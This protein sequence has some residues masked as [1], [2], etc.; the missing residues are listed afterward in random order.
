MELLAKLFE[1][2]KSPFL[3]TLIFLISGSISSSNNASTDYYKKF[4][5]SSNNFK[6]IL[7]Y[8][9][10]PS[11]QYRL[12]LTVI[13][14]SY[15]IR[16]RPVLDDGFP[17]LERFTATSEV[18]INV[19]SITNESSNLIV[20]HQRNLTIYQDR[21][22][23]TNLET[24]QNIRIASQSFQTDKDFYIIELEESFQLGDR[25]QIFIP[26]LVSMSQTEN[27]GIYVGH[28]IDPSTN[29]TRYL[30]TTKLEP[31]HARKVFPLFNE[32]S[33]KATFNITIGRL[34][35]K[36]H[37]LSNMEITHIEPDQEHT[38]WVW[39]HYEETVLMSP[40]LV[41][42]IVS[43]FGNQ[44]VQIDNGNRTVSTWALRHDIEQN[45][46]LFGAETGARILKYFENKFKM[47]YA[48][49]KLDAVGLP[50]FASGAMENFGLVTYRYAY[51][52]WIPGENT[53]AERRKIAQVLAHEIAHQWYG[54]IVTCAWWSEIWLNEGFARYLQFWGMKE[55]IPEFATDEAIVNDVTQLAMVFDQGPLTHPVK[56][57]A[58]SPEE[59][60][61]VFDRVSYEKAAS[62]LK[63]MEGFL[64][65]PI[66]EAGF[67]DVYLQ[68][69]KWKSAYQDD[70]FE[71]VQDAVEL[72]NASSELLPAG[73]SVKE[74][75]TE[76]TLTSGYPL[77]RVDSIN[78]QTIA[79]SQERFMLNSKMVHDNDDESSWWI[80]VKVVSEDRPSTWDDKLPDLWLPN[81]VSSLI[82][83]RTDLDTSKWLMINPD[84]TGYYRVLYDPKL[85]A[86]IGEQLLTNHF[87]I[88]SSSRSQLLDD[89]FSL[90]FAQYTSIETALGMT[91]Y[92][93]K[94]SGSNVWTA[95]LTHLKPILSRFTQNSAALDAF[96]NYFLPRLEGALSIIGV[97]Q[98]EVE[99]GIN[100][101]LRP[102]LLDMACQLNM[103]AC[104]IY[105]NELVSEWER[106]PGNNPVPVDIRAPIYCTAVAEPSN[107]NAWSFML[108]RFYEATTDTPK[109]QLLNA[110][111]CSKNL[112]NLAR[113]LELSINDLNQYTTQILTRVA[114][115]SEARSLL[116]DFIRSNVLTARITPA[117][118]AD[119]ISTLS[120]YW[121]MPENLE[122]LQL[123]IASNGDL[124]EPVK[125]SLDSSLGNTQ[126]T[127]NWWNLFGNRISDWLII[128]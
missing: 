41:C 115:N 57:S 68:R 90:A 107:E 83:S 16:M 22:T 61:A 80:P 94:E 52:V 106:N 28:Y 120:G 33:L 108:E 26:Y 93:G 98:L 30:S 49:R 125:S 58:E 113:F 12:N 34:D 74:I 104:V 96:K 2:S 79:I 59:S 4:T 122:E 20:M 47:D 123:F 82:F 37:S 109:T 1:K 7:S 117:H 9:H 114:M 70:L 124:L 105:A 111:A 116:Y 126:A 46:G 11:V 128:N 119:T 86:L 6:E 102:Q 48:L 95:V 112:T 91:R 29:E 19:E 40:Y 10:L 27:V 25:L 38:G 3:V 35:G 39:D 89:Y 101:T 110:L 18:T 51:L 99:R 84:A 75:M 56:N 127:I 64:T 13:P 8:F 63:M 17:D 54:N 73:T 55:V 78:Q 100:V 72:Y 14:L 32:P 53:E 69:M 67:I 121:H 23:I 81:N 77:V 5:L 31:Y 43:D 118:F 42:M 62:L 97:R 24:G 60:A 85:T 50:Q 66:F 15:S 65:R 44:T 103:Q 92:L 21:V 71:A 36:Y 87:A 88:S 76:W 45:G